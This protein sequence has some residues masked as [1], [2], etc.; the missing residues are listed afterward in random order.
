MTGKFLQSISGNFIKLGYGTIKSITKLEQTFN[1]FKDK[2]KD[3][4]QADTVKL[5]KEL[6]AII[7]QL[8]ALSKLLNSILNLVRK[9]LKYTKF[10]KKLVIAL[11]VLT[12]TLKFFPLP[13]RWTTT[14]MQTTF[15]DL[16]SKINFKLKAALAVV[17][18]IDL[19]VK[20]ISNF[21]KDILKRINDL[22]NKLKLTIDQLSACNDREKNNLG[23]ELE[24]SV[25][26]LSTS[27][28]DLQ[29]QLG[30]LLET[31]NSYKGFTFNIIEEETTQQ[32][33]AK[34]RYAIAINSLGVVIL[35]GKPSYATD[36]QV[37][38]DEL[39]LKIDIDNLT[40]YSPDQTSIE[41]INTTNL[42]TDLEQE[43]LEEFELDSEDDILA[44]STESENDLKELVD[45]EKSE[46]KLKEKY[47]RKQKRFVR[48]LER[49]SLKGNN[50]AKELLNQINAKKI[51]ISDAQGEWLTHKSN[52]LLGLLT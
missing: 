7:S 25:N 32:V 6:K 16:L 20:Y 2:F 40:G 18:G 22:I 11:T 49:K 28:E 38:I 13:A 12:K 31:N 23:N 29:S 9:I 14:G 21:L 30:G 8:K 43:V 15:S 1:K 26:N 24:S 42:A 45:T 17:L 52:G 10:L 50:K 47:N 34:R 4:C 19:I 41:S 36:T 33:I 3:P 35:E 44:D 48:F 51:A 27:V 39:K 5:Q 37:L 46:S